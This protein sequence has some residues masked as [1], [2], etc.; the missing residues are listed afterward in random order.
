[1]GDLL[2]GRLVLRQQ[3]LLQVNRTGKMGHAP[4]RKRCPAARIDKSLDMTGAQ[5]LL[6]IN[7]DIFEQRQQIDF[8]LI[9]RADQVVIG[10]AGQSQDWSPIQFRV[11]ESIQKMDCARPRGGETDTQASSE[12]RITTGHER[13]SLFMA[14]LNKP[15]V[16]L[17]GAESAIK[18]IPGHS[19]DHRNTPV[20]QAVENK[21]CRFHFMLLFHE[22][23]Q[24]SSSGSLAEGL[25]AR[26]QA[27]ECGVLD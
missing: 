9:T 26:L 21:I 27:S 11:I 7:G 5:H 18:A 6:V 24:L 3:L 20:F 12:F 13:G 17:A 1:M 15:D 4:A 10:L 8:L 22:S 14:H 23:L 2:C 16:L 19:K 25:P